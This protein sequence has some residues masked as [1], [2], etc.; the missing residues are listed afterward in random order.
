MRKLFNGELYYKQLYTSSSTSSSSSSSS[1]GSLSL[2]AGAAGVFFVLPPSFG[3]SCFNSWL[4]EGFG[5]DVCQGVPP[6]KVSPPFSGFTKKVRMGIKR[7]SVLI[8]LVGRRTLPCRSVGVVIEYKGH[9]IL[10]SYD[11]WPHGWSI[12]HLIRSGHY[13]GLGKLSILQEDLCRMAFKGCRRG[14][15]EG[16]YGTSAATPRGWLVCWNGERG[17]PK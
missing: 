17:W 6:R 4:Q 9:Y 16:D 7:I 10:V 13:S 12:S 11:T 5:L 15:V 3:N 14:A 1:S 8:G 2:A